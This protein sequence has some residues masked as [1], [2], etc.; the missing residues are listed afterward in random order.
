MSRAA[1]AFAPGRRA[2]FVLT[3]RSPRRSSDEQARAGNRFGRYQ[4][5]TRMGRSRKTS[6]SVARRAWTGLLAEHDADVD[7][8]NLRDARPTPAPSQPRRAQ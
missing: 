5:N 4:E 8:G 3:V 2:T 7:A 1:A 6:A